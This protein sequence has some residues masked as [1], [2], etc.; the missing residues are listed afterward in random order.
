MGKQQHLRSSHN[1]GPG[2]HKGGP[3]AKP[4]SAWSRNAAKAALRAEKA[5]EISRQ[6]QAKRAEL[7][8]EERTERLHRLRALQAE[9][10]RLR[11]LQTLYRHLVPFEGLQDELLLNARCMGIHLHELLVAVCIVEVASALVFCG[12]LFVVLPL[13]FQSYFRLAKAMWWLLLRCFAWLGLGLPFVLLLRCIGSLI[14]SIW[15]YFY[16]YRQRA[17]LHGTQETCPVCLGDFTEDPH[18][19]VK[20]LAC[21]H[22]FH[23][24]CIG[25]WLAGKR[26]CPLCRAY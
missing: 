8:R 16:Y 2:Q 17:R 13:L 6:A 15:A 7:I 22:C 23:A 4:P 24:E 1:F 25:P 26:F 12:V 3:I 9:Q 19:R 5:A 14:Q 21:G 11:E 10:E 20:T 18:S